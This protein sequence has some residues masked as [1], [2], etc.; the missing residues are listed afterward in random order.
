[1][2]EYSQRLYLYNTVTRTH[3]S[4]LGTHQATYTFKMKVFFHSNP[5]RLI[6]LHALSLSEHQAY[7]RLHY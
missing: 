7:P 3:C 2:C 6:N 5:L 1:M 4:S